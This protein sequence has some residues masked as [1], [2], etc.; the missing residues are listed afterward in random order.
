[1]A[2]TRSSRI[3]R[4]DR[5]F[6]HR[7]ADRPRPRTASTWTSR[8]GEA[9]GLVG[10]SGCGKSVTWLAALGLL[11]RPR[12]D[13]RRGAARRPAIWSARR[14]AELESVRG[15][16]IAMIFQD[17]SS[18]LNPVHRIGRQLGEA[19]R[20]H[21]GLDGAAARGR[22]AAAARPG[23]HRRRQRAAGRLS[24]RAV[25]RHE[26]ARDDRH[27]AGRPARPAGRRRADHRARRH[28]PG[29]DPGPAAARSGARPAWRWC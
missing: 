20:L 15:R 1:M 19:L 17:P 9:L 12:A 5:R 28:H 25:R 10:E 23:R 4:P 11:R 27:G 22:G 18:S 29:A 24:A 7:N 13:R 6:R 21:R 26:P 3:A 16:R 2:P 8:R 14:R